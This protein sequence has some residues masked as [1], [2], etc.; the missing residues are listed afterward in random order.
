[1]ECFNEYYVGEIANFM[2]KCRFYRKTPSKI[3]EMDGVFCIKNDF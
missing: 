3:E 2:G 1:M